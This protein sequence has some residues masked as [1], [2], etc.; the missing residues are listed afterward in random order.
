MISKEMNETIKRIQKIMDKI[1]KDLDEVI[2]IIKEKDKKN[3]RIT[4]I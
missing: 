1:S 2:K 4:N 3:E